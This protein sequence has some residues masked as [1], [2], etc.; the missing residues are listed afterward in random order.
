MTLCKLVEIQIALIHQI[1]IHKIQSKIK[2]QIKSI[3]YNPTVPAIDDKSS[4]KHPETPL[5]IEQV[6]I[7]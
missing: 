3:R 4:P 5:Q 1:N 7:C 6:Q 2:I